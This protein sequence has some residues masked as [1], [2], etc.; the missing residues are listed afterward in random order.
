MEMNFKLFTGET[1]EYIKGI[2]F[3]K[4]VFNTNITYKTLEV[5]YYNFIQAL[6]SI[7]FNG[8]RQEAVNTIDDKIRLLLDYVEIH[9]T[10]KNKYYALLAFD[11]LDEQE[12]SL[13]LQLNDIQSKR[14]SKLDVVKIE[15]YKIDMFNELIA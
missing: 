14:C 15:E 1:I 10:V 6:K 13:C 2:N 9:K 5:D 12:Y 7:T 3:D 11:E 8:I 4:Y